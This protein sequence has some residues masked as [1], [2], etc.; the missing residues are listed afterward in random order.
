MKI[1]TG[2]KPL[3]KIFVVYLIALALCLFVFNFMMKVFVRQKEETVVPDLIGRPVVD[4]LDIMAD[5]N[6]YI[7]KVGQQYN[8]KIPDGSIISQ[9]PLPGSVVK[10]GKVIKVVVSSG[11]EVIF[12]PDL[13]GKTVR[14]ASLMIRQSG[15][16]LGEIT[17]T[18]SGSVKKDCITSQDPVPEEIVQRGV[19]INLVISDG[20]SGGTA[21]MTMP[22]LT[23]R[24][25]RD[26]ENI[27]KGTGIKVGKIRVIADDT[28]PE[29]TILRHEPE[30]ERVI[31]DETEVDLM[32]SKRNPDR[33]VLQNLT[34]Y[35]EVSQGMTERD[36]RIFVMDDQG[37][38]A[39]YDEKCQPGTK[40]S[41][42]VQ[43]L[44]RTKVKI[45]VNDI[46]VEE[47]R[48]D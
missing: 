8:A 48:Y 38:R 21:L 47:R 42:P 15:L 29:G 19:M 1:K 39:V 35:Y 30:P 46:M 41:V 5:K 34:I 4:M 36:V 37:K 9:N 28:V 16:V 14:Q 17:R 6:L 32:V 2:I 18:Y 7:K 10:V 13:M 33:Q 26:I 27:L 23:G 40:I 43:I 44:G 12:V 3:V 11:G 22:N 31:M 20:P 25:I 45:Y 24:N